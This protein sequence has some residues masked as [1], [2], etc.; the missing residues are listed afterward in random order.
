M[1]GAGVMVRDI[2]YE[3]TSCQGKINS[4][5]YHIHVK[6][7]KYKKLVNVR[8]MKQTQRY[9]EQIGGYHS[10]EGRCNIGIGD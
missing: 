10:E 7:K 6:P 9:R 2:V 3:D 1:G 8:K 5:W 4:V